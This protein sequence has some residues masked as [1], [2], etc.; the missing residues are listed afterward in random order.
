M[1]KKQVKILAIIGIIVLLIGI[2]IGVFVK[3]FPIIEFDKKVTVLGTLT[4][5]LTLAIGVIFPFLIK[6]WI[7]DNQ[8]IKIYLVKEI[9]Q[10][11]NEISENKKI[12]SKSYSSGTFTSEERDSINFTFHSAELQIESIQKQFDVSFP[13]SL[14]LV[15]EMKDF[16]RS[17]KDYLTGGELMISTF[18]KVDLTFYREHSNEYNKFES[19]LKEMIHKIHRI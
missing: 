9:E 3:N 8:T 7:D 13:N 14:S 11:V 17:Y 6:K 1:T 5:L 10:L 4:F 15:E 12:I 16:F 19:H 18:N 2:V